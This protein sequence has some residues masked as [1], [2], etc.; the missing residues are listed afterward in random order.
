MRKSS[1][2]KHYNELRDG[3]SYEPAEKG[4][5]LVGWGKL[6]PNLMC[7]YSLCAGYRCTKSLPRPEDIYSVWAL[8]EST[9]QIPELA[10]IRYV[11]PD[12][13]EFSGGIHFPNESRGCPKILTK[14]FFG[15]T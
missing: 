10:G 15:T 14:T 2:V 3:N 8:N 7:K 5:Y 9:S 11:V 12:I 13:P 4:T 6:K 1:I